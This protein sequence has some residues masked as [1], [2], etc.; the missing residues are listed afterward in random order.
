MTKEKREE[1]QQVSKAYQTSITNQYKNE[2]D[3]YSRLKNE[4]KSNQDFFSGF[5]KKGANSKIQP[6]HIFADEN[7]RLGEITNLFEANVGVILIIN[8]KT[9]KEGI[10][11]NTD[12]FKINKTDFLDQS[13]N[14]DVKTV[15]FSSKY[16]S[17]KFEKQK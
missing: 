3:K 16:R 10:D 8:D 15:T 17:H 14:K 1:I 2:N 13:D 12:I 7:E 4:F 9:C 6:N 11:E 5:I